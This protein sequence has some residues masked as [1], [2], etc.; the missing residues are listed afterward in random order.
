MK[1]KKLKQKGYS[2]TEM[3]IK[4]KRKRMRFLQNLNG[5]S[6]RSVALCFGIDEHSVIRWIKQG[7]LK[8]KR[9]GT[10]RTEANGGDMY[11]IKNQWIRKF[12]KESVAVIDFRKIDKYWLIDLLSGKDY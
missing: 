6:A 5:Y 9:R 3:G 10:E 7:W 1:K 12:I 11:F 8:A 2:R 4:L